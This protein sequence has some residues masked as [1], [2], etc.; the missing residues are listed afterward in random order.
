LRFAVRRPGS[1]EASPRSHGVPRRDVP[2]RVHVSVADIIAGDAAEEGLALTALRSDVPAR[3]ATLACVPRRYF[4]YPAGGL[5]LQTADQQ[6]PTR[7]VDSTVQA[8]FRRDIPA[9][10]SHGALG[11][12]DH[13]P[14]VQIFYADH[15]ES[16]RDVCRGLL[17]PVHATV[18]F[19]CFQLR[20]RGLG[21]PAPVRSPLR[22]NQ[23]HLKPPQPVLLATGQPRSAKHLASG[24]SRG[25]RYT[26]VDADFPAG[27]RSVDRIRDAGERDVPAARAVAVDPERLHVVWDTPGPSEPDPASF[28]DAHRANVAAQS[29]DIAGLEMHYPEPFVPP[30]LAPRGSAVGSGEEVP[31]SLVVVADRLLLDDHAAVAKPRV[32]RSRLGKLSAPSGETRHRLSSRTPPRLLLDAEIPYISGMCTVPQQYALLFGSRL[33]TIPGHANIISYERGERRFLFA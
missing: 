14:D 20:D 4:L 29:A 8:S 32:V 1:P 12:S 26:P 10:C 17:H 30:G 28:G 27:S 7:P 33:K 19:A 5:I 21:L 9:R 6:T 22:P 31:H 23:P 16:A 13:G 3:R 2:S 11:R 24:Q 25:D 15:I 18:S